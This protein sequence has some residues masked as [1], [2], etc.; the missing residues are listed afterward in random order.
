MRAARLLIGVFFLGWALAAQPQGVDLRELLSRDSGVIWL[1]LELAEPRRLGY[2]SRQPAATPAVERHARYF[3]T[4]HERLEFK[5]TDHKLP[6]DI[7]R[8][9]N[10]RT[11]YPDIFMTRKDREF[12][13]KLEEYGRLKR[14]LSYGGWL[15]G[16]GVIPILFDTD[17]RLLE[18]DAM[19]AEVERLGL[20]DMTRLQ[21][22]DADLSEWVRRYQRESKRR[23]LEP[24]LQRPDPIE[25][26]LEPSAISDI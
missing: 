4:Q 1:D 11:R 17:P 9:K 15:C 5:V 3:V 2:D 7:V 20:G 25:L 14:Q 13:Q 26:E 18:I 8:E 6:A 22:R 16:T 19:R 12:R 24:E 10:L 23:R 21:K